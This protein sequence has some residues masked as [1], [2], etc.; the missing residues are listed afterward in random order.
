MNNPNSNDYPSRKINRLKG[1][2]YSQNGAYFITF[3]VKNNKNV[4]WKRRGAHCAPENADLPLSRNG[5]IAD[6]AIRKISE[7]YPMI[8]V[9]N[10]VVMPNHIHL[11]LM[12]H[13]DGSAIRSP[14][15]ST[16]I[17]QLKG[18]ITKEIG[19]SVWQRSFHDH[20]IRNSNDYEM[21]WEYIE[22]N[23][24]RFKEDCFYNEE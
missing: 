19:Y 11:L 21:I 1:Y 24:L 2:D 14:T 13:N 22:G 7:K 15:V 20:I 3:C 8:S 23:P 10:F 16:V 5:I 9:D 17:N 4:F 6:R 12:I 18:A